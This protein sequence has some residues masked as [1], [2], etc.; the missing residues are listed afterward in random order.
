VAHSRV[1]SISAI[2]V[3]EPVLKPDV[4]DRIELRAARF[5]R[6]AKAFFADLRS[7]FL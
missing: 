3:A 5:E 6:L 4:G 1:V 2:P 7:R